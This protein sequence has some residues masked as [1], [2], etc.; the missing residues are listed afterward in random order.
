MTPLRDP[1]S[2]ALISTLIITPAD[3]LLVRAESVVR[4]SDLAR[5]RGWRDGIVLGL[6]LLSLDNQH[7]LH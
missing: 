1:P 6:R 2:L 7:L 5:N 4:F 3:V